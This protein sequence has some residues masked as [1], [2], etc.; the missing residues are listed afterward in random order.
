MHA[1]EVTFGKPGDIVLPKMRNNQKIKHNTLVSILHMDE[2][3]QHCAGSDL[4]A[5]GGSKECIV[6]LVIIKLS[7]QSST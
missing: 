3:Q 6:A 1:G 2:K 4:G 5:V 7:P